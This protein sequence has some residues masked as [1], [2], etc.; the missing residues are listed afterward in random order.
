MATQASRKARG[1]QTEHIGADYL[2]VNGWPF[3]EPVGSSAPGCDITGTPGVGWEFK[4]RRDLDLTGWLRQAVGN[5]QAKELVP[6]LVF[7]PNGYGP[8]SVGNW[9]AITT[10]AWQCQLLRAAG[11]GDP[12][13]GPLTAAIT[14]ETR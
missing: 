5:A 7:R 3:A 1:R 12:L 14:W 9:P 2:K 6:I 4:A 13:S 11:F 10:F 8:A